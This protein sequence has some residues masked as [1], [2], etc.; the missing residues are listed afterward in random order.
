[1]DLQASV[2]MI[3]VNDIQRSKTFYSEGTGLRS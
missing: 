1:M 2:I 3:G